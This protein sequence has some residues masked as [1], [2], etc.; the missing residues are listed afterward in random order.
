MNITTAPTSVTK[1]ALRQT[2][3]VMRPA[4]LRSIDDTCGNMTRA[5]PFAPY[6][7]VSAIAV[8]IE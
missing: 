4:S 3:G 7:R 5:K 1:I 2:T 6:H 8:A